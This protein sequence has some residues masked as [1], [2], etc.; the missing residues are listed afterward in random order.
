MEKIGSLVTNPRPA[1]CKK[2]S[3]DEKYRIRIGNYRVL[4][5]IE[6]EILVIFIVKV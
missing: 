3:G 1:G 6:D 5:S 2:L 4:Y